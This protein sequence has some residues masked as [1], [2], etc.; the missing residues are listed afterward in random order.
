MYRKEKTIGK[1]IAIVALLLIGIFAI[2]GNV[3]GAET[4]VVDANGNGDYTTIQAAIDAAAIGDTIEVWSGTYSE[5]VVVNKALTIKGN[6]TDTIILVN[7]TQGMT[8]S[9]QLV[10]I[11]GFK[12]INECSMMNSPN[13]RSSIYLDYIPYNY[14]AR[15]QIKDNIFEA[16][17]SSGYGFGIEFYRDFLYNGNML[18]LYGGWAT[19]SNNTFINHTHSLSTSVSRY[20][21]IE[22]NTFDNSSYVLISG[23]EHTFKDNTFINTNTM[24]DYRKIRIE[25]YALLFGSNIDEAINITVCH[26]SFGNNTIRTM[27]TT[28]LSFY[29]NTIDGATNGLIVRGTTGIEHKTFYAEVYNNTIEGCQK[30]LYLDEDTSWGWEGDYTPGVQYCTFYNNTFKDNNYGIYAEPRVENNTFYNNIFLTNSVHAYDDGTNTW[31]LSEPS[32]GNYWDNHTGPDGDTDGFV[33]DPYIISGGGEATDYLP[34]SE[35]PGEGKIQPRPVPPPPR[36]IPEKTKYHKPFNFV[37]R[38]PLPKGGGGITSS[39]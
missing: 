22:N 18:L 15:C 31:N 19:V 1:T 9:N 14:G 2:P 11:S 17:E 4:I 10:S 16:T 24:L 28:N 29:N 26:N 12:F 7:E 3:Q 38:S 33:D 27:G 32:G 13:P 25:S 20:I 35:K 39:Q 36:K 6:G 34:L 23:R 21:D 5:N 8:V 30:G 37:V